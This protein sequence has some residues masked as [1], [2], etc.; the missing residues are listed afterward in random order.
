MSNINFNEGTLTLDA[1]IKKSPK[2][3]R[4]D[5]FDYKINQGEISLKLRNKI[6]FRFVHLFEGSLNELIYNFN[7]FFDKKTYIIVTWSVPEKEMKLY[8][9]GELRKTEKMV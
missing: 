9:N 2:A 1:T 4:F 3:T 5:F 8:M 7:E 6:E